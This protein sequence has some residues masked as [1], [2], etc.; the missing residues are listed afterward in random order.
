MLPLSSMLGAPRIGGAPSA[1]AEARPAEA[2][3][4][5]TAV[6]KASKCTFSV[7]RLGTECRIAIEAFPRSCVYCFLIGE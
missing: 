7:C 4:L 2:V 5:L 6:Q 3:A 1:T